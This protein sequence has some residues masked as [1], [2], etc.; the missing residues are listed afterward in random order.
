[1]PVVSP[2]CYELLGVP[3]DAPRSRLSRAWAERRDSTL[4]R[5]DSLDE[6][7]I[8]AITSRIDEAFQ[9][10]ADGGSARRYRMYR[11][12]LKSGRPLQHPEDLAELAPDQVSTDP[13]RAVPAPVA[14][15]AGPPT[16][17][18][19]DEEPI[20]S[21]TDEWD[22]RTFDDEDDLESSRTQ[23]MAPAFLAGLGLLADVVLAIPVGEP[24]TAAPRRHTRA[25]LPPWHLAPP[26]PERMEPPI[27]VTAPG[28]PPPG[29]ARA[30]TQPGDRRPPWDR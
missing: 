5:S 20:E 2:S 12:Q 14:D 23:A 10:L 29:S 4:G 18:Q 15:L 16:L 11:A 30:V 25:P 6:G 26:E 27:D 3:I 28:R 22:V 8:D 1:M 17:D 19:D 13:G 9:I 7:D 21:M 24:R